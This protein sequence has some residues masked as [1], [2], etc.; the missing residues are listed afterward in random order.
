[1]V[2]AAA[3]SNTDDS[4]AVADGSTIALSDKLA[5]TKNAMSAVADT[6]LTNTAEATD[7]LLKAATDANT[8]LLSAQNGAAEAKEPAFKTSLQKAASDITIATS[9]DAANPTSAAST[10]K[11]DILSDANKIVADKF[12]ALPLKSNELAHDLM[13]PSIAPVPQASLSI[14]QAMHIVPTERLAPHV[15]TPAWDQALGQKVIWMVG[16]AQQSASLSL[17]PPDLGPMQIILSVSNDQATATFVTAQPEVRQALEAAIPKLREMLG[18]AGIQ[19]GATNVS[20]QTSNQQNTP[21][22]QARQASS[23]F[24]VRQNAIDANGRILPSQAIKSGN[25]LVDTFA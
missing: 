20:T 16:G 10:S 3:T 21:E 5:S 13:A 9:K 19:L 23:T 25:G 4:V 2:N 6:A 22:Q 14:G 15:G 24:D 1:M 7:P 18:E 17:N 8:D 12:N 11:V